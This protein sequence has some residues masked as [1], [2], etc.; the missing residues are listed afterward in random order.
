MA[1]SRYGEGSVFFDAK[2]DLWVGQVYWGPGNRPKVTSR[3]KSEML[4]KL[5]ALQAD[6]DEGRTAP[7]RSMTVD[8]WLDHWLTNVLPRQVEEDTVVT[9]TRWAKDY[10]RPHL[11]PISL[12]DLSAEDVEAMMTTLE[13]QGLS[14]RTVRSA[15]GLLYQALEVAER[16]DKVR[17]NVVAQTRGPKLGGARIDDSL[18]ADD[19]SAVLK[20]LRDDRLYALAVLALFLGIRP[21]ELYGLR[22]EQLNLRRGTIDITANLKR[23]RGGDWYLKGPKTEAGHRPGL[24][25]PKVAVVA[26]RKHQ[27]AQKAELPGV[28]RE[29]VFT[30]L[31]NEPLKGRDVLRWWHDATIRAGVGRRRFYCSRHTAATLMLNN[32]VPLEVVSKILGHSGY[33]ITSD[34]YAKV[35]PGLQRQAAEVMDDLLG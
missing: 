6:K 11:G 18:S 34:I 20:I 29:F 14:A 28:Q 12:R 26:L 7:T 3:S 21:G 24:P 23:R 19:A 25:L 32:G 9:Y 27:R 5:R 8:A 30:D 15:R 17:R 16:R 35:G 31:D 10:L 13:A 2:R 4:K 33:A 22:W 1:A